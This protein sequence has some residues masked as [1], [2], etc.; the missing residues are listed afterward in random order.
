M[1]PATEK[2]IASALS[3]LNQSLVRI[4]FHSAASAGAEGRIRAMASV[5]RTPDV[6][7]AVQSGLRE[8]ATY[9]DLLQ[10]EGASIIQGE[11]VPW[12]ADRSAAER[13]EISR[14]IDEGL[15]AGKHPGVRESGV[16]NYPK[17]TIAYDLQQYFD[18]RKS[19]ASTV[20]RTELGRIMN[21]STLQGWKENGITEVDV[22]DDEGPNSCIKCAE[23]NGQ[24]WPLDYALDHELEHPNCVRAFN[25]VLPDQG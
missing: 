23:A 24:R 22:L 12:L 8:A 11:K 2:G 20:A 4:L 10:T 6:G 13:D 16:G 5:G 19:Q 15:K 17:D 9:R 21:I 25:P 14:I 3:H 18:E 7:S 1:N